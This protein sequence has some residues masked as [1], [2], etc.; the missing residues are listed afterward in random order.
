MTPDDV[1]INGTRIRLN[2]AHIAALLWADWYIIRPPFAQWKRF[3]D[4]TEVFLH[5]SKQQDILSEANLAVERFFILMYSKTREVLKVKEA[6]QT[7]FRQGSQN[8]E[9]I[10]PTEAAVIGHNE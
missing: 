2:V 6:R 3:P 4:V 5:L 1:C 10:P 8:I 9:N 7:L